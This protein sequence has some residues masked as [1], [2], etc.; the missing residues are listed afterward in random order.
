ML[1][2]YSLFYKQNIY[3]YNIHISIIHI[4]IIISIIYI[5]QS[6]SFRNSGNNSVRGNQ[7]LKESN[8][9]P[10]NLKRGALPEPHQTGKYTS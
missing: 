7:I 2:Y 9:I 5:S 6:D 4:S 3:K 8:E 1:L 10:S